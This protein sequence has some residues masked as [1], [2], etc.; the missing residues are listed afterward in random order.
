MVFPEFK[1][2]LNEKFLELENCVKTVDLSPEY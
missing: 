2:S 1:L